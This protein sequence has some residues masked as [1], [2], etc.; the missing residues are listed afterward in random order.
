MLLQE[1]TIR[2]GTFLRRLVLSGVSVDQTSRVRVVA[3]EAQVLFRQR[4]ERR[5]GDIRVSVFWSVRPLKRLDRT[6]QCRQALTSRRVRTW[7][8]LGSVEQAR[9]YFLGGERVISRGKF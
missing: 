8:Q 6:E 4:N 1:L 5:R 3:G 9:K 2:S 7:P